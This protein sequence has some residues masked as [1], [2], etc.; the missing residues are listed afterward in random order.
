MNIKQIKT[1]F[2]TAADLM[3]QLSAAH[4]KDR[5]SSYFN[6][7]VLGPR[8][9][10]IDELGYLPFG[11]EEANLLFQVVATGGVKV[12]DYR[13]ANEDYESSLTSWLTSVNMFSAKARSVFC[14]EQQGSL[15]SFSYFPAQ[16]SSSMSRSTLS[17]W[18][19]VNVV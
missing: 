15:N 17:K 11:R 16:N 19:L 1:R 9:L 10:I 12:N 14:I 7:A 6:R 3:L 8:L 18:D 4:R 13:D 5:L 2:I